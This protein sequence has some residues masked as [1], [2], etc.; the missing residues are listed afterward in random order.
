[1]RLIDYQSRIA[2][3]NATPVGGAAGNAADRF[4][5]AAKKF[6]GQPYLWGGGHSSRT[7]IQRV[8][9]S[10]LVLQA[11]RMIGRNLDGAARHQQKMGRAVS[12]NDLQPGDLLFKG[13]PA[14]HVG[15]Y[16]GDNKFIHAPKTGDVVRIQSL[17]EYRS[18]DS[19]R[20]VFDQPGRAASDAPAAP[21]PAPAPAPQDTYVPAPPPPPPAAPPVAPIVAPPPPPPPPPAPPVAMTGFQAPPMAPMPYAPDAYAAPVAYAPA[22]APVVATPLPA[23]APAENGARVA[24]I[25]DRNRLYGAAEA[26]AQAAVQ[27][28]SDR[29]RGIMQGMRA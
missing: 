17:D 4:I 13:N 28:I 27:Q 1:M 19:A 5:E 23:A 25:Y 12:M 6:L 15:I 7:G 16:L 9:C 24:T 26:Q 11:A 3:W 20:R 14:T 29:L 21:A 8:D 18:F 22:P 2:T 10:G